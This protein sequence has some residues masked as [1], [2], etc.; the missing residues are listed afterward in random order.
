MQI[1]ILR[2]NAVFHLNL[3]RYNTFLQISLQTRKLDGAQYLIDKI[4]FPQYI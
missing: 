2:L 4:L 3:L 1:F